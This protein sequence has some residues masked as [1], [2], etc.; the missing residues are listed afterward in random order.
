MTWLIYA[1]VVDTGLFSCV[2]VFLFLYFVFLFCF[3][4]L[5]FSVVFFFFFF[6]LFLFFVCAC[7]CFFLLVIHV[8][9]LLKFSG[10]LPV[11][12]R[13][14]MRKNQRPECI[15]CDNTSARNLRCH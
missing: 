9:M 14:T 1:F 7:V 5:F 2:C 15:I 10:L 12:F 11:A 4:L 6:F 8:V 13:A 3:L